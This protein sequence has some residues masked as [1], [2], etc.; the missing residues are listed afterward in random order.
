MSTFFLNK[1]S[2]G[3]EKDVVNGGTL[4]LGAIRISFGS[5]TTFEDVQA[6]IEFLKAF[7][8]DSGEMAAWGVEVGMQEIGVG[9]G[10][11]EYWAASAGA[12]PM[13]GD[14]TGATVA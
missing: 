10:G 1:D 13:F 5:L 9:G 8:V 12:P 4:P 2:C 11:G 3:D 14:Q 6:W 7:Y